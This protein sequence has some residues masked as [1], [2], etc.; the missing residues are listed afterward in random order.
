MTILDIPVPPSVNRS[1]MI[2]RAALSII[3]TWQKRCDVLL[4]ANGQYRAATKFTGPFELEITLDEQQCAAD[5]D[6]IIKAAVDYLRRVE[7]I[8]NDSPQYFRRLLVQWGDA[9]E[10]CRLELSKPRTALQR[11]LELL[12]QLSAAERDVLAGRL[13][14]AA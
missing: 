13:T 1:R 12:P 5:L 6:N 4:M 7:L 3:D 10:G 14:W 2:N 9:P 11:I 8:R